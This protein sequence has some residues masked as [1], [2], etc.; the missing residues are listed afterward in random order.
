MVAQDRGAHGIRRHISSAGDYHGVLS[1]LCKEYSLEAS[2][3]VF[4]KWVWGL[5]VGV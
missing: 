3:S 2:I 4:I 5:G 1:E